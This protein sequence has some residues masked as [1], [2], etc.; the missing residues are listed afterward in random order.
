[1]T[2]CRSAARAPADAATEWNFNTCWLAL[3]RPDDE[4]LANETIEAAPIERW[5]AVVEQTRKVRHCG[6]ALCPWRDE[7]TGCCEHSTIALL[8]R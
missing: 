4:P 3:E 1:M 2:V 6:D 5:K 7:S 8:G